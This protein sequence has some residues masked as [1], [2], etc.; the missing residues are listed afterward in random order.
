MPAS[1]ER[2]EAEEHFA[3]A[4]QRDQLD[5]A[6]AAQLF[7]ARGCAEQAREAWTHDLVGSDVARERHQTRPRH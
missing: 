2:S 1:D 5:Q 3:V 7:L 6:D 4:G